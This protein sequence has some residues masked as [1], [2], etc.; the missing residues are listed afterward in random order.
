M[1]FSFAVYI[2]SAQSEISSSKVISSL[3][4]NSPPSEFS[5]EVICTDSFAPTVILCT[6]IFVDITVP[7]SLMPTAP[8][9]RSPLFCRHSLGT[10]QI[11]PTIAAVYSPFGTPQINTAVLEKLSHC[12]SKVNLHLSKFTLPLVI[13]GSLAAVILLPI[14]L[15]SS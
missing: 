10:V 9:L 2:S 14:T 12:E 4:S 3:E 11:P 1:S 6:A 8:I 5:K 7:S 13:S 15:N